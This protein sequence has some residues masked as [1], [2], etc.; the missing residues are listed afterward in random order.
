MNRPN[1]LYLQS[2]RGNVVPN[3]L[4]CHQLLFFVSR[5]HTHSTWTHV[6]IPPSHPTSH[7]WS[8]Q[9]SYLAVVDTDC[10]TSW[11]GLLRLWHLEFHSV[12]LNIWRSI[13][14]PREIHWINQLNKPSLGFAGKSLEGRLWHQSVQLGSFLG[15]SLVVV[16]RYVA[17][18]G[19][20]QLEVTV[21]S[22]WFSLV[23]FV[24]FDP[25]F[26]GGSA[27]AVESCPF[28]GRNGCRSGRWR[29]AAF[30]G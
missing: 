30:H 20:V 23:W 22:W 12:L 27:N 9:G 25:F 24:V 6:P 4:W 21:S 7:P 18:L 10:N 11:L 19:W 14:C 2:C 1:S 17:S 15:G 3:E 28:S 26:S 29:A 8:L 13:S 16:T 5:R